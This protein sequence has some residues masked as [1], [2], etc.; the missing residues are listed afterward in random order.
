MS[1]PVAFL[2]FCVRLLQHQALALASPDLC[3]FLQSLLR[4][5]LA[6]CLRQPDAKPAAFL[7]LSTWLQKNPDLVPLLTDALRDLQ[8]QMAAVGFAEATHTQVPFFDSQISL[9][10][11][12]HPNSLVSFG[13]R[14]IQNL[15]A[16][17]YLNAVMQQFFHIASFSSAVMDAVWRGPANTPDAQFFFSL[18]AFFREIG[19]HT[20]AP[21][22][23]L[24]W[25]RHFTKPDCEPLRL[26]RQEDAHEY[27]N[28][29]LNKCETALQNTDRP[30]LVQ[31]EFL[32]KLD[33]SVMCP[34]CGIVSRREEE[35]TC[36]SV[37]VKGFTSLPESLNALCS[38]ETID[39]YFCDRCNASVSVE[40]AQ[41]LASTAP[42]LFFQLKRFAFDSL[43]CERYKINDFFSFPLELDLSTCFG[44]IRG[45]ETR[46]DLKGLITHSGNTESGHYVSY[47]LSSKEE[48]WELNDSVVRR[49]DGRE[50]LTRARGSGSVGGEEKNEE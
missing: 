42:F 45:K 16:T 49:V 9:F 2:A 7:F 21:F 47:V 23:P 29:F 48:W 14:G 31:S 32:S 18:Q 50:L 46:Y 33:V 41:V 5:A 36:L 13:Y 44:D 6:T 39:D 35:Y 40:K 12:L 25:I 28:M 24:D 11:L 37:D 1:D 4:S 30:T 10:S 43:T 34:H 19:K 17:C 8:R 26:G 27:L 38:A 3:R 20:A 15:G 22:D